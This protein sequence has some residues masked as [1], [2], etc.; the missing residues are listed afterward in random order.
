MKFLAVRIAFIRMFECFKIIAE[1]L[2]LLKKSILGRKSTVR[3]A[4]RDHERDKTVRY[5]TVRYGIE[6][7]IR[8][9]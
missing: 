6:D 8:S 3:L 5:G 2:A 1:R 7:K 4:L 9:P